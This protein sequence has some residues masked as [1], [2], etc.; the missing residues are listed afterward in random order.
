M[1][2]SEYSITGDASQ[3][4]LWL[5]DEKG[6]S[7]WDDTVDFSKLIVPRGYK[8]IHESAASI[9]SNHHAVLLI[10]LLRCVL[11]F[12]LLHKILSRPKHVSWL[13]PLL[14]YL[15]FHLSI[16]IGDIGMPR[17]LATLFL[18][19][20]FAAELGIGN[21]YAMWAAALGASSL[22]YPPC[23]VIIGV[24]FLLVHA[25][26]WF[27]ER[28][29]PRPGITSVGIMLLAVIVSY[30]AVTSSSRRILES[31]IGGPS[32]D[33]SF[34][35]TDPHNSEQ[36]RIN[37]RQFVTT[38]V[39]VY[40]KSNRIELERVMPKAW[41]GYHRLFSVISLAIGCCMVWASIR[42]M[43]GADMALATYLSGA[44]LY[45]LAVAI[46]FRLYQPNR[47]VQYTMLPSII[48]FLI[49]LC[50]NHG[51]WASSGS[52]V[53]NALF[54]SLLLCA[55]IFVRPVDFGRFGGD[56]T[57]YENVRRH[58]GQGRMLATNNLKLGDMIPWFT[59][60]SVFVNHESLHGVYYM[61]QIELQDRKMSSW[62]RIFNLGSRDS[63]VSLLQENH[64]DG[65]LLQH[66]YH[67]V[68][69]TADIPAPHPRGWKEDNALRTLLEGMDPKAEF[70]SGNRT[71]RYY[72]LKIFVAEKSPMGKP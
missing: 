38:P 53:G 36:G 37:L 30:A 69:D 54:L 45:F 4:L 67:A 21:R 62:N 58:V 12:L 32:I 71:F 40:L 70:V 46:A 7:P 55:A 39:Y 50:H 17:S 61:R 43:R 3:H 10:D 13:T 42:G 63:L 41:N 24:V 14:F 19:T 23:A 59:G 1:I 52:R 15:L 33:K 34:M 26:Q 27:R 29:F 28:R 48:M 68:A 35:L 18:L 25:F 72:D 5:N 16:T 57:L 56:A 65:L 66:P 51:S 6:Y 8:W 9:L 20:A 44:I 31:P 11:L 2:T 47:Y 22:Y 60:R 49:V 64:I